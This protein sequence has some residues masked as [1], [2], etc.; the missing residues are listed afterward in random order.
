[1]NTKINSS[2]S[3]AQ[4]PD[5]LSNC[6]PNLMHIFSVAWN[7]NLKFFEIFWNQA[8]Q[9]W[10]KRG[11]IISL[12]KNQ[13]KVGVKKRCCLYRNLALEFI[14]SITFKVINSPERLSSK[15]H[16]WYFALA[17]C[18]ISRALYIIFKDL[19]FQSLCLATNNIVIRFVFSKV[20]T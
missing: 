1:M 13:L 4:I 15:I 19:A 16:P 20:Y 18:L 6:K 11:C 5:I 3:F 8:V 14:S 12:H 10:P 7:L 17:C 9:T 2:K